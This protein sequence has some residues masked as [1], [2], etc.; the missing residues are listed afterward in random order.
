MSSQLLVSVR[1]AAEAETAIAGGADLIDVKEPIRG[2]LGRADPCVLADV[3]RKVAGR[4]PVSAALGE[5]SERQDNDP[6]PLTLAALAFVKWGLAGCYPDIDWRRQLTNFAAEMPQAAHGPLAV[7][8]AYA[9]SRL[10]Q[11]PPLADVVDFACARPGVLLIDTWNK[12]PGRGLLDWLSL[13]D[14]ATLRR[15]CR[16]HGVR[17]ALAG[18][19]GLSEIEQLLDLQPDWFA[20][21]GAACQDGRNSAVSV[22]QV[23]RLAQLVHAGPVASAEN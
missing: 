11:A 12:T 13:L 15:R 19:L 4:R 5:L 2:S 22:A 14:L 9:D 3:L 16:I 21:R 18:S 23:R 17:L 8:V 20:V 10:A 1:S 7:T 6:S